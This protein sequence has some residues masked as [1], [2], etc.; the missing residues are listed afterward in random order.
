MNKEGRD[1]VF[2]SRTIHFQ[3]MVS[4]VR[5]SEGAQGMSS[6]VRVRRVGDKSVASVDA[7]I[8]YSR[9]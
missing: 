1:A 9:A 8:G 4:I 6:F 7:C 3:N 5:I 2:V